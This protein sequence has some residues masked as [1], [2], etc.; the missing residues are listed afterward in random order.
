[1]KFLRFLCLWNCVMSDCIW[2]VTSTHIKSDDKQSRASF[3]LRGCI[4]RSLVVTT[5]V[6]DE[7]VAGDASSGKIRRRA[8]NRKGQWAYETVGHSPHHSHLRTCGRKLDKP[9][10]PLPSPV[11]DCLFCEFWPI[12]S[13]DG[14][15]LMPNLWPRWLVYD[16][17]LSPRCD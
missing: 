15:P 6:P 11:R 12:T 16:F 8:E 17:S 14:N 3:F 7:R 10:P 1:M 9:K 13:F 4:S 2:S 5:V